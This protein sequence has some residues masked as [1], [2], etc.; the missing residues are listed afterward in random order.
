M[1]QL[2]KNVQVSVFTE[3]ADVFIS[4]AKFPANCRILNLV[5]GCIWETLVKERNWALTKKI[6]KKHKVCHYSWILNLLCIFYFIG[7]L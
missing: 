5:L 7:F 2:W 6:F 3:C 1:I 4:P